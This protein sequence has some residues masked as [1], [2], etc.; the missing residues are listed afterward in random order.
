MS[1]YGK[2][3]EE[4]VNT[5]EKFWKTKSIGI[6]SEESDTCQSVKEFVNFRLRVIV[7]LFLTTTIS[8]TTA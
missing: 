2:K 1:L 3:D 6:Q 5:L 4:L 8:V 7:Y